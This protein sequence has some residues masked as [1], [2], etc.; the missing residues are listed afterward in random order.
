MDIGTG[1]AIL[2]S[3]K[4]LYKV[5]GP[6]ADYLGTE[7]E[8]FTKNRVKNISQIFTRAEKKLGNRIN[9]NGSVSPKVLR[10]VINEGSYCDDPLSTEYFSG[11][12]ASSKTGIS[13]DDRGAYFM[14]LVSRLSTYQIRAHYVFYHMIKKKFDGEGIS[15]GI[16]SERRKMRLFVPGEVF[17]NAMNFDNEELKQ[18]MGYASHIIN[19]LSKEQLIDDSY[20]HGAKDH[21]EQHF[22]KKFSEPGVV[23]Q[24]TNFGFELFF[25]VYGLGM[26]RLDTFLDKDRQF[27]LDRSVVIDSGFKKISE[28]QNKL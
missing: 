1:L 4:L 11:V 21:L 2:G 27:E 24:P 15:I 22:G 6:T 25:W 7:V 12:L 19:G 3:A 17:I 28:L 9:S 18:L 10:L 16:D 26:E 8:Q 20:A 23:F 13:R 5:L 14:A